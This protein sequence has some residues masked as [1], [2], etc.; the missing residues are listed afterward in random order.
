M[1]IKKIG[2][3]CL[4]IEENGLRIMTDPGAFSTKQFEEKNIDIILI[5]HEHQDHFH[6]ESLNVV[7]Q[8]NPKAK[9]ITNHSVGKLLAK[10][11]AAHEILEH[12]N[13]TNF[14][15]VLIEGFGE[16]HAVIYENFGQVQN[17]GYFISNKLFYPGDSFFS[18]SKPVEI[19]AVP[20]A[21]PWVKASDVVDFAKGVKPK[22]CFPVHDGI[23]NAEHGL[24]L[25]AR[26]FGSLLM[27][28]GINFKMLKEGETL[29]I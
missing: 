1:K 29:E 16:K 27:P 20:V 19:L 15:G 3:C 21:G 28:L 9:I 12:G 13:S 14:G 2:H 10:E 6:L 23:L 17:T 24:N 22:I 25:T 4:V 5:T 18:P 26:V 11:G 8:N 7:L